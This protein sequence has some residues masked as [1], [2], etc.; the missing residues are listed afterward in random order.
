MIKRNIYVRKRSETETCEGQAPPTSTWWCGKLPHGSVACGQRQTAAHL[1]FRSLPHSSLGILI[2]SKVK[3]SH[4]FFEATV[5][6]GRLN[7]CGYIIPN[8]D[9]LIFKIDTDSFYS[10]KR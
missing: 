5:R 8:F 6:N 3:I 9:E 2:S 7:I 4:R 10:W 1:H